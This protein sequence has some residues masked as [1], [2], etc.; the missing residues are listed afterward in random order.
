MADP[1]PEKLFDALALSKVAQQLLLIQT[2]QATHVADLEKQIA[3]LRDEVKLKTTEVETRDAQI[4]SLQLELD[5]LKL[6]LARKPRKPLVVRLPPTIIRVPQSPSSPLSSSSSQGEAP[7][8]FNNNKYRIIKT[9]RSR[10]KGATTEAAGRSGPRTGGQSQTGPSRT[11]P[12]CFH[13]LP[14][15]IQRKIWRYSMPA[16]QV[17]ELRKVPQEQPQ[18]TLLG[19]ATVAPPKYVLI[20]DLP[21][22]FHTHQLSRVEIL[23]AYSRLARGKTLQNDEALVK[24][25]DRIDSYADFKRDTVYI[26]GM[27]SGTIEELYR[28]LYSWPLFEN[29]QYLAVGI[30]VWNSL[31]E[32]RL[33]LYDLLLRAKALR[34]IAIVVG[35]AIAV[36]EERSDSQAELRKPMLLVD[37]ILEDNLEKRRGMEAMISGLL[38]GSSVKPPKIRM[39]WLS[40]NP[41]ASLIRDPAPTLTP[42]PATPSPVLKT[43]DATSRPAAE[44]KVRDNQPIVPPTKGDFK[45]TFVPPP[46][47]HWGPAC[48]SPSLTGYSGVGGAGKFRS[49]SSRARKASISDGDQAPR[50]APIPTPQS[51]GNVPFVFCL[52]QPKTE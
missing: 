2:Q 22:A 40:R 1:A 23:R 24:R 47:R 38:I 15:Q 7:D 20:G 16:P 14:Y 37:C 46:F 51:P 3:D 52:G 6:D 10:L 17:L 42:T 49:G 5:N 12:L 34:E 11:A 19:K 32:R 41:F 25:A 29:V 43:G 33:P 44:S 50:F 39:C 4:S 13:D 18:K 45:F 21:A 9:P 27:E 28:D 31:V 26:G 36:G 8:I 30:G 48:G 35:E